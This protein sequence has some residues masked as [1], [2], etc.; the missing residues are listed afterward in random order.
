MAKDAASVAQRWA[1]NLGSS[2]QKVTDGVMAVTTAPGAA[3]AR[4]VAV[5]AQNTAAAQ[6]KFARNVAAVPLSAWQ[7]A[8]INKGI[9]RLGSGAQA[10]E[11]KFQAFMSKLLPYVASGRSSLTARGSYDQNKQRMVQWVDYM[12]KFQK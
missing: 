7:Q 5:W 12:H 3:A 8:I 6:G 9:P 10:A 1:A 11:P 2:G 4:Q